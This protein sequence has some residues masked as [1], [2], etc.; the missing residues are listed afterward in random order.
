V[1]SSMEH[2]PFRQNLALK[3]CWRPGSLVMGQYQN[4]DGY[5]DPAQAPI[6]VPRVAIGG[7]GEVV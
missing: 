6:D 2:A 7:L 3:G 5:L 1:D 4:L